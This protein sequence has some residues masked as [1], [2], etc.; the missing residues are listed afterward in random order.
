ML[1]EAYK[2]KGETYDST[3]GSVLHWP[4]YGIILHGIKK[5][6]SVFLVVLCLMLHITFVHM[7]V[8]LRG[9]FCFRSPIP[10]SNYQHTV[11][12]NE[13]GGRALR[14]LPAIQ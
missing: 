5:F 11:P 9:A 2:M 6:S 7:C 13:E 8:Y 1:L 3:K 4:V 10:A 14:G 12:G